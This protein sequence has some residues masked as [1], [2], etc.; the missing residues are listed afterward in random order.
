[1]T[2]ESAWEKC[3]DQL[4]QEIPESEFIQW[5]KP[6]RASFG[7]KRVNVVAHSDSIATK[8]RESYLNRITSLVRQHAG[9]DT[10][11]VSVHLSVAAPK[12]SKPARA[13]ND[14]PPHS[15]GTS[16]RSDQTFEAFVEGA[17]NTYAFQAARVVADTH[18]DPRTNPL[19]IYGAVGL[20]KTHLL[21]AIGNE[22]RTKQPDLRVTYL[23]ALT[24]VKQ[25]VSHIQSS[26]QGDYTDQLQRSD[27]FLFDDVQHIAG[28]AKCT[29][30]FIHLFDLLV[31]RDKQVVLTSQSHPDS[32]PDLELRLKSRLKSRLTIELKSIDS[33]TRQD[34]LHHWAE[35]DGIRLS[36]SDA[37]RLAHMQ[38]SDVRDLQN[39][40]A[41]LT[42]R[43]RAEGMWV[44]PQLVEYLANQAKPQRRDLAIVDI[45]SVVASHYRCSVSELLSKTRTLTDARHLAIYLAKEFS[46]QTHKEIAAQFKR[47]DHSTISRAVHTIERRLKKDEALREQYDF[48]RNKLAS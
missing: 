29:E 37:T 24:F 10:R 16:L 4:R 21:H 15:A 30:E 34:I 33:E 13:A 36:Q 19:L 5:L 46:K 48:L 40:W 11:G 44:S 1:M 31:G 12:R 23:S 2:V 43:A 6:L 27:V 22:L 28:K 25:V 32:T 9:R 20:G 41:Q 45:Q 35:R 3:V 17:A 8:V 7:P 39:I 14:V 47:K 18:T 42:M 26:R 38:Y